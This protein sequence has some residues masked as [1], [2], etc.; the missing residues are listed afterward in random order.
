LQ[1]HFDYQLR[2]LIEAST[3]EELPMSLDQSEQSVPKLTFAATLPLK[4]LPRFSCVELLAAVCQRLEGTGVTAIL[5]PEL[6]TFEE[7]S[8][9][10]RVWNRSK[11][12]PRAGL[13][14]NG[15]AMLVVGHDRAGFSAAD[16][17]QLDIRTWPEA[18]ARIMRARAHVEIAEVR[19]ATGS[20]LDH[21]YDRAAAVTIV[22]AAV[23]GLADALAVVWRPSGCAVPAEQLAPLVSA[24][25]QGQA[26]VSL[27]LGHVERP[28]GAMT[29]GFYPL[30]GAEIEIASPE[31]P[32][33]AAFIV[34]LDL[35]A[36]IFRSGEPPAHGAWLSYDANTEF[37]VRHRA[38][39][40]G[41]GVP[42]VALM[43]AAQPVE[44]D[45]SAG[46][47]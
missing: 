4:A 46:A 37:S 12:L 8:D 2:V 16:L 35:V 25:K 10:A 11:A 38:G 29:R 20:D 31:L 7:P 43:H 40:H 15:V 47:A 13:V 24:L 1:C 34:A 22:A 30:L 27:W 26:P 6:T 18:R 5:D 41:G 36:E 21:N 14:V 9:E 23:A 3:T 42:T 32:G 44:P 45:V 39:G 19:A 17:A 28:A 33:D